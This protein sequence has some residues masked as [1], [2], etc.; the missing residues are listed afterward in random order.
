MNGIIEA[1]TPD[2]IK[3]KAR[4]LPII[5]INPKVES[6]ITKILSPKIYLI[7][8]DYILKLDPQTKTVQHVTQ[9]ELKTEGMNIIDFFGFGLFLF[10][11]YKGI[12][13][14]LKK[15]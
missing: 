7:K 1:L 8:G 11:L 3:I 13:V 6:P 4:F 9:E 12:R 15:G 5:T 10:L 14:F 2:L